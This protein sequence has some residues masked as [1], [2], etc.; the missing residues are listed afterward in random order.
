[1]ENI[2]Q[3]GKSEFLSRYFRGF[4]VEDKSFQR[5]PLLYSRYRVLVGKEAT[6]RIEKESD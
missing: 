5:G 2:K 4:W 1:M 3:S 6:G